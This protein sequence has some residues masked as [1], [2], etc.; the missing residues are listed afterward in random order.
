MAAEYSSVGIQS[1]PSGQPILFTEDRVPCT[2]GLVFHQNGTGVF[3]I[4][5]RVYAPCPCSRAVYE[6]LYRVDISGHVA[7][8]EGGTVEEIIV[9]IYT[10][11]E[12]D[13][14]GLVRITP[15]A[16]ETFYHF[17][18]PIIAAVPSICR[19]SSISVEVSTASGSAVN[20]LNPNIIFTP[21][22]V[23]RVR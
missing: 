5:S 7:I 22:G 17:S 23:Q 10:D 6:S 13:P 19:C 9:Q 8:P 15:A 20:V 1:V 4:A 18:T 16:A 21:A 3:R 12:A 11:G 14:Q 2:Q